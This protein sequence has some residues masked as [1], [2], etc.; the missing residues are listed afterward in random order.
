MSSIRRVKFRPTQAEIMRYRG[1]KVG[2]SAVPGSGKT[3]TLAHLA[4]RLVAR[5]DER[6][7]GKGDDPEVLVVTFANSAVNSI[8]ARVAGIL[9]AERGLLPYVGYRV[10]TLHGL[11]HDIVRERPG[12]VGLAEDFTIVDERVASNVLRSAVEAW[13][14]NHGDNLLNPYLSDEVNANEKTRHRVRH[15]DMPEL[16]LDLAAAFIRQAKDRRQTPG[17]LLQRL[18][19]YEA[20][21][22]PLARFGASVYDDYQRALRMRGA[23]DFDDLVRLALEALDS[24][25]DYL[26]RLQ[27]RWPYIL[28]D[29]AQDSSLLQEDVL[30]RLSGGKNWVRV[31][32][33]N[34]AINTTFTTADPTHLREFLQERGVKPFTLAQAGRS[35]QPIMD[36]ANALVGWVA[37]GHPVRPLREALLAQ[38]ILP[39]SADD[40]QPNPEST[41]AFIHIHYRSGE[42]PTPERELEIVADSLMK[43]VAEHPDMTVAALVPEN[44]HGFKL[45]EKLRE[46]GLLYEE[47]LRSTTS[48]R[49][50]ALRLQ[51]VLELLAA[52][53]SPA[54][55]EKLA[56]LYRDFW[57]PRSLGASGETAT[58]SAWRET[59]VKALQ[60]C[61]RV[62]SF[63][64]PEL[65]STPLDAL[66]LNFEEQ[67]IQIDPALLTE[68]LEAFRRVVS[69]WLSAL[70]LPVDQLVLTIGQ[71]LFH[72]PPEIA[73]A[74]KIAQLLRR[75]AEETPSARMPDFL[76]ELRK[77]SQN[78]RRFLGFD[79]ADQGYEPQPG[80]I[81][82]ATM[83]AAKG[84]EWD[85][86]YLLA[87]NNYSFP[88]AQHYDRY[89]GERWFVRQRLNLEAETLAQL[90]SLLNDRSARPYVE[91]EATAQFRLDYAAER[92]RLL[93]VGMTRARRELIITWNTGRFYKSAEQ[94]PSLPLV[95]LWERAN[96]KNGANGAQ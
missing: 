17:D 77:I 64:W 86:V 3:F 51:Q 47:L 84:L 41:A 20:H 90:E 73:L 10:R 25:P 74:H 94:Q 92:L 85:R 22:L 89:L 93:Y 69:R 68:D 26:R 12:L 63:L 79:D 80:K 76:E 38:D 29:E 31:G 91:G 40:A 27:A 58:T 37:K 62:E 65:D 95:A 54:A 9:Q 42:K 7:A 70:K 60:N 33:P 1:G 55:A 4:A 52:P 82:I 75:Y 15:N 88:S 35:A 16:A 14:R 48:T 18:E 53:S 8:K 43:W 87:V 21:E 45:A 57:W 23:V 61:K 50:S 5:L 81:T 78:E 19:G 72:S 56:A 11:A 30:R 96:G 39:V 67:D 6:R 83:H 2:I 28:E 66:E 36:L 59:A 46:R 13:V 32:D 34:Q 24:D 44:A 71:D 49:D